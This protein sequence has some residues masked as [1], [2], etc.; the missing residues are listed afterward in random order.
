M[1]ALV[2][3]GRDFA[4]FSNLGVPYKGEQSQFEHRFV[5]RILDEILHPIVD[6]DDQ[7]TWLPP[8]DTH[9]IAGGA[10]GADTA[11]V[12]WAI[13]NWVS[14]NEYYAEWE[15]YGKAAGFMR[16]SKMLQEGKPDVVIAFP[17]GN[18]TADMVRKAKDAGVEVIEVEYPSG[19]LTRTPNKAKPEVIPVG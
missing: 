11:A 12:D 10:H 13:V 7:E 4:A 5:T 6:K 17:G 18:G 19:K 1:K 3:G 16:N 15:V 8:P 14:F 9:I 2:C